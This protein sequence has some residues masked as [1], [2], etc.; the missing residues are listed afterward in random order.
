MAWNTNFIAD[1]ISRDIQGQST[2]SRS[3]PPQPATGGGPRDE[4]GYR[5][6]PAVRQPHWQL[7]DAQRHAS[8]GHA[9]E[10]LAQSHIPQQL[11]FAAVSW[12][13]FFRV[14][15]VFSS[16]LAAP[17]ALSKGLTRDCRKPYSRAREMAVCF[18]R[19]Q[20][21]A[22][23]PARLTSSAAKNPPARTSKERQKPGHHRGTPRF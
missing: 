1:I 10:Q 2:F 18:R 19:H 6:L 11:V 17:Q 22:A 13:V 21:A 15:I 9:H 20:G 14:V 12:G 23:N 3:G 8:V 5:L 7:P 16:F 4:P